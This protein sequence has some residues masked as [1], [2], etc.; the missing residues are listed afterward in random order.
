MARALLALLL[1]ILILTL[2]NSWR[3]TMPAVAWPATLMELDPVPPVRPIPS[4]RELQTQ[5]RGRTSVQVMSY[6]I[7]HGRGVSGGL[8]LEEIAA[9]IEASGADIIG[10]QEVDRNFGQRSDYQDQPAMLASRLN[11]HYVYGDSLRVQ[12]LRP[13]RGVGYYGNMILSRYPILDSQ[14]LRLPN[15]WGN[16][17]RTAL[18]ATIE[19]PTGPI[20]V[21]VT[22]LGLSNGD[23]EAQ[24]QRLL[25]AVEEERLPFAVLGDFNALAQTPEARAMANQLQDVGRALEEDNIGTFYAGPSQPMPRID[26][27]WVGEHFQPTSYRVIPSQASDHLAVTADLV[28]LSEGRKVQTGKRRGE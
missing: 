5:E 15:Q 18:K 23:R 25:G 12:H 16:E 3:L 9:V 11:M 21:W 14:V 17:P 10:L 7:H 20:V 19:T 26:Y 6:N 4:L 24:V 13:G 8:D 28:L 1:A 2:G 22:H 27:I